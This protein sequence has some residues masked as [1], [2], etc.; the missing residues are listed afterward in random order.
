M[1]I[2]TQTKFRG[3]KGITLSLCLSVL[4]S[5]SLSRVNLTLAITFEPREIGLSYYTCVF[6]VTIPLCWYQTF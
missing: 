2:H 3:Y 4:P 5:V 6:L 1:I